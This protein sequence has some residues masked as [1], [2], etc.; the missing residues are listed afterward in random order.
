MLQLPAT[1]AFPAAPAGACART[2]ELLTSA[3]QAELR[4]RTRWIAMYAAKLEHGL[5]TKICTEAAAAGGR[6]HLKCKGSYVAVDVADCNTMRSVPQDCIGKLPLIQVSSMLFVCTYMARACR[7][8][9]S[10][11]CKLGSAASSRR[12][13]GD[14]RGEASFLPHRSIH[15]NQETPDQARTFNDL[16]FC[17]LAP[18]LTG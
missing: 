5:C 12:G 16:R 18:C 7:A 15:H 11:T 1:C 10:P 9:W 4:S 17:P 2:R 8:S 3:A 14:W 13:S 6:T